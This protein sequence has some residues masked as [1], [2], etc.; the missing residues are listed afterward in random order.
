MAMGDKLKS[1]GNYAMGTRFG[2]H[3]AMG[4]K[5]LQA[6]KL[7]H[8]ALNHNTE[9]IDNHT[10]DVKTPMGLNLKKLNKNNKSVLEK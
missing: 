7:A 2:S 5:L 4:N 8:S 6:G 10:S 3:I 1:I 9:T